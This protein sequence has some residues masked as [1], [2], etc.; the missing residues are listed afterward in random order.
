MLE[1]NVDAA[2]KNNIK[3]TLSLIRSLNENVKNL[4]LISTDKAA[5]PINILGITKRFTELMCI[6][7]SKKIKTNLK[8]VRF[9][10]VF[11]SRGSAIEIFD[12][13]IKNNLPITITSYKAERYFMSITEACNLVMQCSQLKTKGDI[14]LL[15]M[16]KQIKIYKI[17]NKI[18]KFYNL[19]NYPIKKIGL[20]KGEKLKEIL[21]IN[22][23]KINTKNKDIF[24]IKEKKFSFNSIKE[25]I[26]MIEQN[27]N[28]SLIINKI[29]KI[30]NL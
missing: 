14:Y 20:K 28:S 30:K 2:V 29:R 25:V 27:N 9:G 19:K 21:A 22:K 13:Q 4:I 12:N 26:T 10:N 6:Y 11:G 3:G 1:A 16:G 18:I 15:N 24:S 7:F 8:V 23:K 5:K 17:I